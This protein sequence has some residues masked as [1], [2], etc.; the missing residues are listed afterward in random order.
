MSS[1]YIL[2]V[3]ILILGGVIAASGD[4]IGT[5]V[6]KARL[7]LFKLRP[8]QTATL[9]TIVT[10]SLIAALT[11]GILI[12]ASE[13]LRTGLFDLKVI[14][15]KLSKTR[16]ELTVV[17]E[18][19][20]QVESELTKAKTERSQ[21]E[22]QLDTINQSLKEIIAKQSLTAKQLNSTQ[23]QLGVVSQQK[24]ALSKE[25]TQIQG[26]RQDLIEQRNQVKEQVNQ[27][28]SQVSQLQGNIAQLRGQINQ[29][30]GQIAQLKGQ[31]NQRDR[32]IAK[33]DITIAQRERVISQRQELEKQLKKGISER[34]T[35]LNQLGQQLK[36]REIQLTQRQAEL[37]QRDQQ[38]QQRQVQ[39]SEQDQKL[40][41]L[42]VQ[43]KQGEIQ[44]TQRDKQLKQLDQQFQQIETQLTQRD[45]QLKQLESQ[46]GQREQR[47]AFLEREVGKLEQDYQ[48]LRQGNV[49]LS[50]NEVLAAAVLRVVEPSSARRAIDQLLSQANRTSI[51]STQPG[52]KKTN[53]RVVQIAS[54]Q[55]D[56]LINQIQD[57]RDYVV[58]IFSAGNYVTGE[59]QVEVFADVA[60]NQVVFKAGDTVAAT[61]AEPAT[62]TEVEIR[63]RIDLLL[64]ASQF[65][66]RRVGIVGDTIL[67]I[68]DGR[69]TTFIRFL[70][71]VKQYK[72]SVDLKAIAAE[73]TYTSGPLKIKLVAI[74]DGQ[75]VFST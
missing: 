28:N 69:I 73:D 35:R 10:G 47:L 23:R 55:V 67:Q 14:Q 30:N 71:Q 66:A 6:G 50:R 45:Q 7:S 4:R 1:G 17:V 24:I 49:V 19:K 25:I 46:L 37:K 58:R 2:I 75:V 9:V 40:K 36:N 11:L 5:R 48:V 18:Q 29:L 22:T 20:N 63:K 26:E 34:E 15:K 27:L 74:K 62:M 52:G 72:Q 44:L 38:L 65:R 57:G 53:E 8:K 21:A 42:E 13:Q 32:Q 68:G 60:L 3:A 54:T 59:K 51:E 33:R 41:T 16:E 12:A 70:E 31:I 39:L 56:Q 61:S 43:L 64:A